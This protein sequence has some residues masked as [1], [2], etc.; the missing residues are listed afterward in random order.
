MNHYVA[1]SNRRQTAFQPHPV[2]ASI[3]GEERPELR[4][5]KKEIRVHRIFRKRQHRA[6][7]R[8][9]ARDGVPGL[10]VVGGF[11]Q[12]RLEVLVL[13]IVK[14]GVDSADVMR[15][16]HQP[17]YVCRIRHAGKF[18]VLG[19]ASAAIARDLNQS[20]VRSHVNQAFSFWRLRQGND[21]PVER[22]RRTLRHRI[23]PP[24]LS[25]DRQFVAIDL[26][27]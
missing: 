10:P 6:I 4:A 1:H 13:V 20:I 5:C 3:D 26:P 19:P 15:R 16:G 23:R 18:V 17:T 9:I 11:Q 14:R 12:I 25:H 7:L 21:I 27:R 24:H 2:R 22:C 8:Q